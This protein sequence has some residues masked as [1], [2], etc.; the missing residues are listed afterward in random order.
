MSKQVFVITAIGVLLLSFF[1]TGCK[2]EKKS[3]DRTLTVPQATVSVE[4]ASEDSSPKQSML[5]FLESSEI[6]KSLSEDYHAALGFDSP[7]ELLKNLESW[8]R[9]TSVEEGGS[10]FRLKVDA[11]SVPVGAAILRAWIKGFSVAEDSTSTIDILNRLILKDE[12]R[13]IEI[14]NTLRSDFPEL[15]RVEKDQP[16]VLVDLQSQTDLAECW[17][18]LGDP[19]KEAQL[20]KRL[21]AVAAL[22][23]IKKFQQAKLNGIQI[24]G[25]LLTLRAELNDCVLSWEMLDEKRERK[26]TA[27]QIET[28]R[29]GLD[30]KIAEL[31][32]D[33]PEVVAIQR[34]IKALKDMSEIQAGDRQFADDTEQD[35]AY[36]KV[37]E[38]LEEEGAKFAT[39]LNKAAVTKAKE[40]LHELFSIRSKLESQRFE[41]KELIKASESE[42]VSDYQVKQLGKYRSCAA[43]RSDVE[44]YEKLRKQNRIL[45]EIKFV[46]RD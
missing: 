23:A 39:R 37:E 15:V 3:T 16:D 5:E 26:L 32:P 17:E 10:V 24:K 12:T 6:R 28:M 46:I 20:E 34:R 27:D 31:G 25:S 8:M 13:Q 30:R 14:N 45:P 44:A 1:A 2:Q 21:D 9:V 42:V 38:Y 41:L 7:E 35:A 18:G 33:A 19:L 22:A 11:P 4:R 43:K 29:A 40:L 36:L